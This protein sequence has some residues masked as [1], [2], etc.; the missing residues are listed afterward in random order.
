MMQGP[1]TYRI[2]VRGTISPD[3]HAAPGGVSITH[4][5]NDGGEVHSMP[6]GR[7]TDQAALPST[8]N[9][10]YALHLPIVSADCLEA[11]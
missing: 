2:T 11:G 1:A 6:V 3:R 5:R 8:L 4:K 7:L 9:T 10:L